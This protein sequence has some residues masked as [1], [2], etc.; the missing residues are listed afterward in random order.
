MSNQWTIR[1]FS[2]PLKYDTKVVEKYSRD[3]VYRDAVA[4]TPG[5]Y[6]DALTNTTAEFSKQLLVEKA[7]SWERNERGFVHL[8]IDHDIYHCLSRIGYVEPVGWSRNAVRVNLRIPA[9]TQN[10]KDVIAL[11]DAGMVNDLSVEVRTKEEWL[12][13]KSVFM[14]NDVVFTGLAVVTMGACR[15]AK[16]IETGGVV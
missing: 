4:L 12:D 10:A 8:D 5:S 9:I 2:V 6:V 15:D 3:R 1:R 7:Y 11:I 14:I 13:E 16:I